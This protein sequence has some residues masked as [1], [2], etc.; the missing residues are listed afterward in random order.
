[1]SLHALPSTSVVRASMLQ[2][3][4]YLTVFDFFAKSFDL[5]PL[6]DSQKREIAILACT[7][8]IGIGESSQSSSPL[9]PSFWSMHPTMERLLM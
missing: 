1:M 5:P 3:E 4:D 6:T 7:G 9:D 2:N 8:Q